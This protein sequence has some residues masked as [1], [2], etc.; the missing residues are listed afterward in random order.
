MF[1]VNDPNCSFNGSGEGTSQCCLRRSNRTQD[2]P[3]LPV[4]LLPQREEREK[5]PLR[6]CFPRYSMATLLELSSFVTRL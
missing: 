6:R 2:G 4:P 3:P 1:I 5:A